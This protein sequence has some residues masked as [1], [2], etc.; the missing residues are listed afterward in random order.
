MVAGAVVIRGSRRM[1]GRDPTNCSHPFLH[2]LF[3]VGRLLHSGPTINAS[4]TY[5]LYIVS[6]VQRLAAVSDFEHHAAFDCR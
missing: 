6:S 2:K 5:R 1:N 3:S 4:L